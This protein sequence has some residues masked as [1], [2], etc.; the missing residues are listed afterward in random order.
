MEIMKLKDTELVQIVKE[1]NPYKSNRDQYPSFVRIRK[2]SGDAL[3][4]KLIVTLL[5][6]LKDQLNISKSLTMDQ[7]INISESII[8]RWY[9]LNP[10]DLK[11]CFTNAI[12]GEYGTIYDRIDM[13]VI[14]EWLTKY[15]NER[16]SKIHNDS[17]KQVQ[18]P[19]DESIKPLI[20]KTIEMLDQKMKVINQKRNFQS[21][22]QF[23]EIKGIDYRKIDNLISNKYSEK[24]QIVGP[25]N[26][27][28]YINNKILMRLNNTGAINTEEELINLIQIV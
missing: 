27:Y 7:M 3:T 11:I 17:H 18:A 21:I 19:I 16:I 22:S 8:H 26:F 23:C 15:E 5:S 4:V 13:S 12:N 9:W 14:T 28:N 24:I 1:I 20:R 6:Y 10:A 25:E 2:N